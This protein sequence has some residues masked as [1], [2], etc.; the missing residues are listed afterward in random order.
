MKKLILFFLMILILIPACKRD[1]SDILCSPHFERAY[2]LYFDAPNYVY[3]QEDYS[4]ISS[5]NTFFIYDK[6][7]E[8]ITKV[9]GIDTDRIFAPKYRVLPFLNYKENKVIIWA[10]NTEEAVEDYYYTYDVKTDKFKKE[11][12]SYSNSDNSPLDLEYYLDMDAELPEMPMKH[13]E[14][15]Y[16]PLFDLEDDEFKKFYYISRFT[17]ERVYPFKNNFKK[18]DFVTK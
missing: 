3:E 5:Y 15:P 14:D 2:Y 7:K 8:K 13:P 11:M 18:A 12:G 9:Y 17:G 10:Y 6:K 4:M 1:D 16:G